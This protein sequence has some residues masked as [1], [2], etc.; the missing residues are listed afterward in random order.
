[1]RPKLSTRARLT[2]LYTSLFI[3]CGATL[4]T[5][6]YALLANSLRGT[7][8]PTAAKPVDQ[9]VI[10]Q[11]VAAGV[12]KGGNPGDIKQK[13]SALYSTGIKAGAVAQ[14]N[15]AL[16]HLL[17]YSLLAMAIL[18][19]LSAIAGWLVA[20][21]I[22]R[23]VQQ[24]TAAARAATQ[25]DLSHRL[26]M[27]GPRDELRQLA[28][29]FDDMLERLDAAFTSQRQFIANAS[30]ELRTPLT[31]MRTAIDVVLSKP[32]PT[33]AE[34]T[35]MGGEVRGAVDEAEQLIAALLTL[36]RTQHATL[37]GQ[38]V[39][40]ATV[41]EDA[42]DG[43]DLAALSVRSNLGPAPTYGDTVL[44]ERMVGNLLQNAARYNVDS[45]SI[46]VSTQARSADAELR[47]VNT[48]DVVPAD[49]VDRLFLPFTRLEG[50]ARQEGFGLGLAIVRSIAEL[51]GGVVTAVAVPTGGLDISVRL[52]LA[53]GNGA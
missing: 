48:G 12:G 39:D 44:L 26:G 13:C 41:V 22:L 53:D 6:T 24:L 29:T 42:L 28:D 1:M 47:I 37:E 35:S 33:A 21:R 40:L 23:P 27:H 19:V 36:A 30:H 20:G 34:L 50:R 52:P 14:R 15:S 3:A 43:R 46:A 16:G 5:V 25:G 45:G 7:T 49:Q 32:A 9:H 17:G 4:L 8:P 18:T 2:L 51:H 10:A 31:V 11:C 38:R